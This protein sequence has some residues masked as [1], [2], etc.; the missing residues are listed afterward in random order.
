MIAPIFNHRTIRR[1][2][3]QPIEPEKLNQILEAAVRAS[4]T[5]NMQLYSIIVTTNEERKAALCEKVH[6]NQQ[7]VKQ[8]PV[9]LTFC[10]DIN[11]FN[12]WCKQ[13]N[14]V[15]GFDN[16]L[17][18]YTASIDACLAAQNAC[19][20]AEDMGLGICYLGTA[21]YN[22]EPQIAL[23]NLP[24][25][26]IPVTS[27]AIGYP[28]EAPALTDRLPLSAVV[29]YETYS[30]YTE[31]DINTLYSEKES[32]P[33]HQS[34]VTQNGTENL[35]QIFTQRRYTKQNNCFF[36]QKLLAHLTKQGFMN[37]E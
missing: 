29:H 3:N 30:P 22:I 14:T 26:V 10:A 28:D 35:A 15:A 25:G 31:T 9:L 1:Y 36:S 5:G 8:A 13:R 17:T 7:L 2:K 27:L 18:F 33:F 12:L 34:L 20:A 37:N 16:F 4:N 23:L 11:R 21:N 32:L 24:E 6:F 19:L